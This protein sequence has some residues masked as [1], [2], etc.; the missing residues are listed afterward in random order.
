MVR[1]GRV[2]II[3]VVLALLPAFAYADFSA[4]T[5]GQP[6]QLTSMFLQPPV[7][8]LDHEPPPVMFQGPFDASSLGFSIAYAEPQLAYSDRFSQSSPV[9]R[10]FSATAVGEYAV[11]QAVDIFGKFGFRYL[12]SD[13]TSGMGLND[14]LT[15]A[16][17][18]N[19]RFGLGVKVRASDVLSLH[20]EW[21]RF[22]QGSDTTSAMAPSQS[23]NPWRE[24]NVFGAGLR[25]GF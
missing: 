18:F 2:G 21:E 11:S 4:D 7:A 23:W 3:G 1:R 19:H 17:Q 10:S 16:T 5:V 12:S 9:E 14:A 15:R 22:A 24:R 13:N 6:P 8:F 25:L 20:F